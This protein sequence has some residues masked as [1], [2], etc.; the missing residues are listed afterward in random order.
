M[1][2]T[3]TVL[4]LFG[5]VRNTVFEVVLKKNFAVCQCS[6]IQ[7]LEGAKDGNFKIQVLRFFS[8]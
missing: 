4:E 2:S 7:P 8:F 6:F 5:L 3:V 1:R